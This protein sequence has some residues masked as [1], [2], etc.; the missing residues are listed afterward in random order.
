MNLENSEN[1]GPASG[2]NFDLEEGQGHDM[3]PIE[4]ACHKDH[5]CQI[6]LLYH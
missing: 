1:C 6:S 5:A 4:S 2:N 3:V